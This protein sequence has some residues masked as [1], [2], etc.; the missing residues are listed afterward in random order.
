[1]G[2]SI[3]DG[4]LLLLQPVSLL[5]LTIGMAIGLVIGFLPGLGGLATLALLI[6]LIIGMDPAPGL[7]FIL[8]AYGAVSFG[9]SI[10]AILFNVPGTGEQVVTPFDGYPMAR[11]GKAGKALGVSAVASAFGGLF[12]VVALILFIPIALQLM[13]YIRS[14]EV[15]ML[16]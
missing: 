2:Q 1:M 14:P 13:T 10:T 11:Q 5:Y 4:L 6:P 7:A 12:G 3:L 15:F 8:G 16:G 9:G